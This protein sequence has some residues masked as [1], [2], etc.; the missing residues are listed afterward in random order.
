MLCLDLL[1]CRLPL[2]ASLQNVVYNYGIGIRSSHGS[3]LLLSAVVEFEGGWARVAIPNLPLS[4]SN[5]GGDP[6]M[7]P[8]SEWELL[9][10]F[11]PLHMAWS[12]QRISAIRTPMQGKRDPTLLLFKNVY[13][14]TG[15][16]IGIRYIEVIHPD[17]KA[18]RVVHFKI[19]LQN[20]SILLY[21]LLTFDPVPFV[22]WYIYFRACQSWQMQQGST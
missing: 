18:C 17:D 11:P 8:P 21:L 6:T 7:M 3:K 20:R 16:E 19:S 2:R 4:L 13:S 15:I 1:Q 14:C 12:P 22:L 10:I 5:W 9:I